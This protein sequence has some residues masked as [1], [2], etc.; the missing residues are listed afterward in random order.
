[1]TA[2]AGA[3]AGEQMGYAPLRGREVAWRS[4]QPA[5]QRP[6]TRPPGVRELANVAYGPDARQT[7]DVY[8]PPEARAAPILFMVH[9]GGWRRADKSAYAVVQ[10]KLDYFAPRG[11]IL[12]S[13]DYRRVPAAGVM[14]EAG[15][16]A[17]A[18]SYVQ[19]HAT[20]WG[21]DGTKVVVMGH[22]AGA[23]LVMLLASSPALRTAA[24]V[25]PWSATVALDSA[26]YDITRIMSGPHPRLY[27]PVFGADPRLWRQAS[28]TLRL[29][30]A[31]PVP[32]L[33]VCSTL[34][35]TSCGQARAYADRAR[36]LGG[37]VDVMAVDLRHGQIDREVGLPSRLTRAIARFI[38]SAGLPPSPRG[39]AQ[40]PG[41]R[42]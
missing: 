32:A 30:S 11:F 9:G 34:R 31:P 1:M 40:Q 22:S 8:V 24:S 35:A 33:L 19:T 15:D 17:T 18:L 10:N 38:A 2:S 39:P 26:G 25:A 37:H 16:V 21:G 28:P 23:H 6:I 27:D 7:M 5:R 3:Q 13:A 42:G 20:S 36:G 41:R 4:L 14:A 29:A 12:V